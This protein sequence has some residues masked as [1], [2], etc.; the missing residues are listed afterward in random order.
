V[1]EIE[2]LLL[3]ITALEA[4][5]L[6]LGNRVIEAALAP[7][8]E[9]LD[10]LEQQEPATRQ[11]RLVSVLFL[12]IVSSTM[13][14]QGLEP[15]EVQE[16]MGGSLKRLSAP[17]AAHGG[18]VIQFVGDGFVAVFGLARIHENDARQAVRAGLSI[19]AESHACEQ[20][21]EHRY[22]L[23]GFKVRIG[24]NTGR[25][26]AGRFFE[27]E[28]PVM[29]LTVSLAARMEQAAQPDTLFISG[30]THK[31]VRGAFEFLKLDPVQAKGFPQ[32]VD[33]YQV[34]ASLPR[35]FRT[36]T[37]GVEGIETSLVGREAE[38]NL[39]KG[40]MVEASQQHETRLVTILGEA[41]V[42]KSRLLYEFD[43]WV[44]RFP[45]GVQA[46][47]ARSSPQM[48]S[49]PF[50]MLRELLS[51]HLGVLITDPVDETRQRL[52]KELS[53]YLSDE[54]EMK[55]HFIGSLLGFDFSESRYLRGVAGD[56]RQLRERAQ[57]YLTQ[58]FTAKANIAAKR[59]GPATIIMLDDLHWADAPSVNFIADLVRTCPNLPLLIVCLARPVLA[60]RFPDWGGQDHTGS[61]ALSASCQ[62]SLKPLSRPDSL[63]L[64]SEILGK[65]DVLPDVL[66]DH[67]LE[68]TEG[69]PFYLE[70]FIQALMDK[71]TIWLDQSAD[72][73]KLDPER[74]G[75]F[76]LPSTLVAL[77][78]ARLDSLGDP[79]RVLLLQASVI[80]RVFWLSALQYI[81]HGMPV[82]N[83]GLEALSRRGFI[84]P[85]E[86]STFAGT[87]EYQFHHALLRDVAY[88]ALLKSDR[89]AY[90]GLAAAWLIG[91][92]QESGRSEEYSAVIADHYEQ[93]GERSPAADWYTRSGHRA[94]KQG[95]PAQARQFFDRALSLLPSEP[96]PS[97]SSSELECQWQALVGRDEVL[98]ILGEAEARMADDNALVG[99]ATLIGDDH[100]LAEAFYR[101]GYYLG[102]RGQ[103]QREWEIYSLGLEASRRGGNRRCEALILGLK[104]F[105]EVNLGHLEAAARTSSAAMQCAQELGD[106]EVMARTLNNISIYYTE[107][108]DMGRSTQ[109]LERQLE[110]IKRMGNVEGEVIGLSNLGYVY[111]L[112]GIPEEAIPMLQRGIQLAQ[113][114][115]LRNF[116]SFGRLN[117]GLAYLRSSDLTQ[118]L[119]ELDQ[120]LP[121]LK[122]MDDILNYAIGHTYLALAREQSGQVEEALST[123]KQA[124]VMLKEIGTQGNMFDA[125]A[126]LVRCL[127]A[128]HQVEQAQQHVTPLWDY[129]LHHSGA[130]MEFPVM[131]YETCADAFYSAGQALLARRAIGA[132]Y[133]E[134]IIRTGKI[135]LPKW[136]QSFLERVPENLRIQERWREYMGA[137]QE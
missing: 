78:E 20:D 45:S 120:C 97:S 122:A 16:V 118:A 70:E 42:G 33:V 95:A 34:L 10:A 105:C 68:S 50:G 30:F 76:E 57:L 44:A 67:I 82:S 127:H 109:L 35:T 103:Y 106:D 23:S 47:K 25:V 3:A 38:I 15:E 80:G 121:E 2:E 79:E 48:I 117:L 13:L 86:K 131:A 4:Q 5:R 63:A 134:L 132:G 54:G 114:N 64:M 11:R 73:W 72:A 96:G 88:Q 129:L 133:G 66:R 59:G 113:E 65:V 21:L 112:L 115:G 102:L 83:A 49:V 125:E 22:H 56:P 7:L 84:Y 32:P 17:V 19:L 136:R 6:T 108:G 92:T 41:G 93:A 24:I 61:S 69:N 135:S 74:P 101:Q 91:A 8:Y 89:R 51:Y 107:T 9:R 29:G 81:S 100:R 60:E 124:A 58:Y 31:H 110:I 126:G 75:R 36:F 99:L 104:V 137:V 55:A 94:R 85:L 98:G 62:M 71:K 43:R 26:V 123:F 1:P 28:S 37:R 128:L 119:A 12:D 39:L 130:R 46:F 53:G 52:V 14:S 87:V 40:T 111:I 27:A 90:H 116:Y 18:S 77:L